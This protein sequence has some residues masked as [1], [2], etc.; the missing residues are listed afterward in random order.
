MEYLLE[1][2][3]RW[4]YLSVIEMS[5]FHMRR[6]NIMC[7]VTPLEYYVIWYCFESGVYCSILHRQCV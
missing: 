4:F 1:T 5:Y 7:I 6:N 2:E 3:A